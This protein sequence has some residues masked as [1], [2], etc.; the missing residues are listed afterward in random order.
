[1]KTEAFSNSMEQVPGLLE[2]ELQAFFHRQR[3]RYD[4]GELFEAIYFDMCEYV[5]RKGKRI[6]PLLFLSTYR[7][8]GGSKDVRDTSLDR[9][10]TRL[11]S[12]H[13]WISRMPSSA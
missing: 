10:S 7:A 4:Y 12:S 13:E 2:Q 11:N 1:M 6:R 9:K 3:E 5:G 8:L